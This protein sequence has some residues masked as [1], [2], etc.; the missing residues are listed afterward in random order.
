[1]ICLNSRTYRLLDEQNEKMK[2]GLKGKRKTLKSPL[3]RFKTVLFDKEPY[4]GSNEGFLCH[5]GKVFTYKQN[6]MSEHSSTEKDLRL[7]IELRQHPLTFRSFFTIPCCSSPLNFFRVLCLLCFLS[8]N[9]MLANFSMF[10]EKKSIILIQTPPPKNMET[11]PV[12]LNEKQ[13]LED[14]LLALVKLSELNNEK[15]HFSYG[16]IF[17]NFSQPTWRRRC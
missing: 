17:S 11:K 3:E 2:I 13:N 8:D 7:L 14:A 1:M 9:L 12:A 5:K 10:T 4:E 6:K 16:K 15:L